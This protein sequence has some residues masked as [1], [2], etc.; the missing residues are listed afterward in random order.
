LS[1]RPSLGSLTFATLTLAYVETKFSPASPI[2]PAIGIGL[3]RAIIPG[4]LTRRARAA[5]AE[6]P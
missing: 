1:L 3:L 4:K 6:V 2:A 5:Y